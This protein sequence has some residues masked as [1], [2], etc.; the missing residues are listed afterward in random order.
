MDRNPQSYRQDEMKV[1]FGVFNFEGQQGPE[2]F[3]GKA[4]NGLPG[5]SIRPANDSPINI[6]FGYQAVSMAIRPEWTRIYARAITDMAYI[7]AVI[8]ALQRQQEMIQQE[9]ADPVPAMMNAARILPILDFRWNIK[10]GHMTVNA[11]WGAGL[12]D[13]QGHL[14]NGMPVFAHKDDPVKTAGF[15]LVEI[16]IAPSMGYLFARPCRN[17][18]LLS[19]AIDNLSDQLGRVVQAGLEQPSNDQAAEA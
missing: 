8:T 12:R 3:L 18:R 11:N 17:Q 19:V 5:M 4:I 15:H 2:A 13:S 9:K 16:D 7:K 6:D 14:S 1:I 10:G